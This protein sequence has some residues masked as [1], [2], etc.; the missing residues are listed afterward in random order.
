DRAD[1]LTIAAKSFVDQF[2]LVPLWFVPV[3]VLFYT[4]K[5]SDFRLRDLR[6]RLGPHPYRDR[7]IPVML[8]NWGVWIPAVVLIYALPLPLQL[9]IQNVVLC[10]WVLM[11]MFITARHGHP[12]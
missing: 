2:I 10:L 3:M 1:L 12:D 6:R 11:L 9:P 7:C 5:E 8:S 4:W